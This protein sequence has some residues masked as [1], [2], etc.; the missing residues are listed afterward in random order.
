MA[1]LI[2]GILMF[3][4]AHLFPAVAK[5]SRDRLA[6]RLGGGPYQ[7]LFALVILGS[8]V[9]IVIGWKAAPREL[10][11]APVVMPGLLTSGLM[12]IASL[13]FIASVLPTNL[14]R[15][16]RHPQMTG[17]LLWSI[18]HLLTNGDSRSLI[19][20]GGLGAWSVLEMLLCSRRDGQ[21]QKPA[22]VARSRDVIYV[23]AGAVVFAVFAY[24]HRWLF[25]VTV[26][27]ASLGAWS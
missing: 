15:L 5:P 16:I 12:F 4:L 8:I 21:W 25:G 18:A 11:Y 9:V 27:P 7:G 3:T 23:I 2:A 1:L 26:V 20:F 13:L 17:T 24:S 6:E 22:P 19:L 10:V 14:R